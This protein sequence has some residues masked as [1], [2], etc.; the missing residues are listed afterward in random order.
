MD[1]SPAAASTAVSARDCYAGVAETSVYVGDELRGRGVGKALLRKQITAADAYDLW[2]LQ[3]SIFP[4]NRASLALHHRA[5]Y[6]TSVSAIASPST[7]AAGV[8][9]SSSNAAAKPT[10]RRNERRTPLNRL[11]AGHGTMSARIG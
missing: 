11:D 7:T 9:P 4:G 2:T 5:G 8:T 1:R 6:R 10:H 3:T